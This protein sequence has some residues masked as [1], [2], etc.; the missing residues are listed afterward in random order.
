MH[1]AGYTWAVLQTLRERLTLVLFALLP[2]H[3]LL[4]TVGTRLMIGPNH[5]P[6]T[7][8]ALW[9]EGL[10]GIIL[11]VA[12]VELLSR[13][14]GDDVVSAAGK[15]R[16][17]VMDFLILALVALSVTVSLAM[18]QS[19]LLFAL[20]FRYDFLAPCAFLILRRVP[21]SDAFRTLFLRMIVILGGLIAAYGIATFFLPLSFFTTLGYSELHSLYLPDHPI[22]AYQQ[23]EHST[24]RRIQ[25][26]LSGPNQLGLWLLLPLG[27]V[28]ATAA[29]DP[30]RRNAL[31]TALLL[32]ALAFT[33]SRSAWIASA[34]VIGLAALAKF[35]LRFRKREWFLL[36]VGGALVAV[37]LALIAP[38]ILLRL[39]STRGHFERPLEALYMM[40]DHP[41]GKGLGTAGPASNHVN[42]ACVKLRPQDDPSWAKDR[43]DLCVFLGDTQVQPVDRACSCPVLTENWYLQI[44]VELGFLGFFLFLA[45]TLI[46]L[47]RLWHKREDPIVLWAL[48]GFAGISIASLFLHA[49]EDTAVAW[50]LWILLS[51]VLGAG[52]SFT[53]APE[54]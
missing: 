49:W 47:L 40:I 27:A 21:W 36:G 45:L 28:L 9:K 3:A 24:L 39:S 11:L 32:P 33:F 14:S 22:A 10:L 2:L 8:L 37:I 54:R 26:T 43:P 48:L 30:R 6:L 41:L 19:L 7:V 52:S 20:G 53:R 1:N 38:T 17:D 5:A 46:I 44:G 15:W 42:D 23:I 16:L 51:L 50:P 25:S 34:C 29:T 12:I 18:N 31:V 35:H 4:V 13:R